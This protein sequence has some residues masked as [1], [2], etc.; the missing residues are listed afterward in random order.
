MPVL[1]IVVVPDVDELN[2]QCGPFGSVAL[3]EET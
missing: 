3:G 1:L 2:C